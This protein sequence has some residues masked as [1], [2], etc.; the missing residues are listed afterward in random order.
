MLIEI[1][2][3][4]LAGYYIETDNIE[5]IERAQDAAGEYYRIHFISK[6]YLE[7]GKFNGDNIIDFIKQNQK[8][9]YGD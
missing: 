6:T 2:T 1:V 7:V 3:R 4:N 9:K 5:I 8:V